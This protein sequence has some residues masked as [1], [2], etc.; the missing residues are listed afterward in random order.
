MDKIK[1]YMQ[2]IT[3]RFLL[4]YLLPLT[5]SLFMLITV[6]LIV[7]TDGGYD[8]LRGMPLGFISN[9]F[10]CSG[11]YDV[12]VLAMLFDLLLQFVI[13]FI[14]LRLIEWLGVKL[15]RIGLELY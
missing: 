11:C 8:K 1:T 13:A 2:R 5:L 6:K 10:G 15:K 3:W 14:L 7:I 12:Y 9:N 4:Q